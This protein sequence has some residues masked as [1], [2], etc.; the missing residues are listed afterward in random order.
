M[1]L[2]IGPC[3]RCTAYELEVF[4]THRSLREFSRMILR[5]HPS[6]DL[7]RYGT[8]DAGRSMRSRWGRCRTPAAFGVAHDAVG[9]AQSPSRYTR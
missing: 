7:S 9:V 6:H 5:L 3:R 2:R 8:P 1:R 4:P